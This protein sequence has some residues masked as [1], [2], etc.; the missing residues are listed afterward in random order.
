MLRVANGE[1]THC[2]APCDLLTLSLLCSLTTWFRSV[3]CLRTPLNPNTHVHHPD[4]AWRHRKK[5]CFTCRTVVEAKPV[6]Q[7][8][9]KDLLAAVEPV[10]QHAIGGGG[11][12]QARAAAAEPFD[13]DVWNDLFDE[14]VNE[15]WYLDEFDNVRRCSGCHFEVDLSP[16]CP[17]CGQ[18]FSDYDGSEDGESVMHSGD[19]SDDRS[20]LERR[21]LGYPWGQDRESARNTPWRMRGKC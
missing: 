21:M 13:T 19:E 9:V 3:T 6:P 11:Q 8:M 20:G 14:K 1:R 4:E 7:Y 15:S 5:C 10:A 2:Q 17:R 12:A 16:E 18:V